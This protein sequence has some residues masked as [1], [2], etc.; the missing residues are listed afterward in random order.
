MR[1]WQGVAHSPPVD[2]HEQEQPHDVDEMPIP[3]SGFQ[4]KMMVGF[5][6]ALRRTP[7]ADREEA[8]TDDHVETVKPD[9]R[10][11]IFRPGL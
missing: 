6:M 1:C 11:D 2:A 8:G 5:E 3:G 4:A 7:Q 9:D 10:K